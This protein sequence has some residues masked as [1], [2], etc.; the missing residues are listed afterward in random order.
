MDNKL[1][2]YLTLVSEHRNLFENSGKGTLEIITDPNMIQSEEVKLKEKYKKANLPESFGDI[3]VIGEDPY[4][5]VVR[6]LVEFPNGEKGGYLRIIERASLNDG[7]AVVILPTHSNKIIL[8]RNFRHGTRKWELEIP[9]GF[10]ESG[11]PPEINAKKE[12][13]EETGLKTS[14]LTLLGKI[15]CDTSMR[16]TNALLFHAEI[17]ELSEPIVNNEEAISGTVFLE[18]KEFEDKVINGD[19][20]DG[21]TISAYSMA[22][23]KGLI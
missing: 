5:V 12:L 10:G 14:K 15:N 22:K 13:Q 1:K 8:I 20:I 16:I 21:F 11:I 19:I 7:K 4:F 18:K 3:G 6:D 17:E 2:K 9:R 23:I